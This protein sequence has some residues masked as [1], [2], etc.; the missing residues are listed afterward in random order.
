MGLIP[1]PGTSACCGCSQKKKKKKE[2]ERDDGGFVK[3]RLLRDCGSVPRSRKSTEKA[4]FEEDCSVLISDFG[5]LG[6][7]ISF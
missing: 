6:R 4:G 1:V 3:L 7:G 5:E 2:R